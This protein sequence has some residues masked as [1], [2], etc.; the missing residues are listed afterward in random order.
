[1]R[2][3]AVGR[4]RVVVGADHATARSASAAS[5]VPKLMQAVTLDLGLLVQLAQAPLALHGL[6][7]PG[8]GAL[9]VHRE[10]VALGLRLL[11]RRCLSS[12]ISAPSPR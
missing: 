4:L 11:V 7:R 5:D 3:P 1:M 6:L 12:D 2:V 9:G 10:P 8:G